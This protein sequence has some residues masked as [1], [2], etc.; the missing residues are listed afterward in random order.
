MIVASS[1]TLV[2]QMRYKIPADIENLL[3]RYIDRPELAAWSLDG[4]AL[5]TQANVLIYRTD[6]RFA[7][8]Y[9]MTR[10]DAAIILN[11]IFMKVW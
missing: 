8:A 5:A 7:P 1:N 9:P 10:G 11:R 3:E 6:S 2:S 4:I